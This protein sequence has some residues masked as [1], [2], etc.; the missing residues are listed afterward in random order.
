MAF[1]SKT[2][3]TFL[4]EDDLLLLN[5]MQSRKYP[6]VLQLEDISDAQCKHLFRFNKAGLN[7]RN[8]TGFSMHQLQFFSGMEGLYIVIRWL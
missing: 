7:N 3:A 8:H 5:T 4:D 1:N 2:L 6:L